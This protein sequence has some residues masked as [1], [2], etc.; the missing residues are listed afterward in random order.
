MADSRTPQQPNLEALK[1]ELSLYDRTFKQWSGRVE[2]ILKRYTAGDTQADKPSAQVRYNLLWSNVQT[3]SAATFS[4]I[5][6]PVAERRFGD[7]D[8][9]GRVA[10]MLLERALKYEIDEY[11]DFRATLRSDVLDRFLGGRGTAWVRYEPHM[12]AASQ[13]L[14]V[15]GDTITDD[16]DEP[17]EELDY[18]CAPV[19][20]V[21]WKDFG[22]S[23]G[24]TWEEVSTVWRR[25]WMTK[26]ALEERFPDKNV[27]LE[28]RR[29]DNESQSQEDKGPQVGEV[30]ERWD[31]PT[32]T[33]IWWHETAGILDTKDD[34]LQLAEFFPCP[35]PLYATL[36]NESLI[37]VP[38]FVLYQDQANSLDTLAARV[39]NL[40]QAMR[41][42]GVYDASESA[43]ARIFTETEDN[44]LIPVQN[45]AAFSD[46]NGLK[47][48]LDLVD[49]KPIAEAL[50]YSYEAGKNL[51]ESVYEITGISDIVRGQSAAS[52]TAT[53]QQIKGQYASLRLKAY[54]DQ[55][56]EF[57]SALIRLKAQVMCAK[58]SPQTLLAIA[59]A[60]QLQPADQQL[61]PQAV[62]LLF[63]ERAQN[64]EAESPNPLRSFR[65]DVEAD[66][67]ILMDEQQERQD[68]IEFLTAV[69]GF[70]EKASQMAQIAPDTI[71][72][73]GELLKFGVGAFKA[74]RQ[75]EGQ[76]DAMLRQQ[77]QK[78]PAPQGPSPE[79]VKAQAD[80]QMQQ[81]QLQH[82][83]QVEQ[84]RASLE[85]Q[86]EAAR[87]QFEA[88]R[89]QVE[90]AHAAEMERLKADS[91]A[92]A[93]AAEQEF[94]RWKAE[95][96]A[97]TKITV[98]QIAAGAKA[99]QAEAKASM[100]GE[101]EEPAEE[102]P[103]EIAQLVTGIYQV[104]DRL[105]QPKTV[106]RGP[107]GRIVGVQ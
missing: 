67:L 69:S 33:V 82:D 26:D 5:P 7:D 28:Q 73:L 46:K 87:L 59:A 14:P 57:A 75:M 101:T 96:D 10:G 18:E 15:D 17:A 30:Y 23:I 16:I 6:K 64:P 60:D 83:A 40:V 25:V 47:G 24:R 54:Q 37:P 102:E 63:G 92:Q 103:S 94:N 1:A 35:K 41:V 97:T 58:F 21:H 74:G 55:V 86:R 22:H 44:R 12:R 99:E 79:E 42:C 9:V 70:M 77:A 4:R 62:Q 13:Q 89:A 45:W 68:R 72:L 56:A 49:L 51:S 100:D 90:E 85:Q 53:A 95:L 2:K 71:P 48:A 107:D 98:A 50:S 93:S 36:T 80:M 81:M 84:M 104:L 66:S 43:I 78:P 76:I 19:D 20:Y 52:E 38:D 106:V 39:G 91:D 105:S 11:A 65:I 61:I 29:E 31:K 34:P 8:Q 27:P 32:K 3:L 88:Q